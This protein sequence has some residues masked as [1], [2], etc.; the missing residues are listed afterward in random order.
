[1]N[2]TTCTACAVLGPID[3]DLHDMLIAI[4]SGPDS[5]VA[6]FDWVESVQTTNPHEPDPAL[7]PGQLAVSKLGQFWA[8]HD[9]IVNIVAV[10]QLAGIVAD[11]VTARALQP[12]ASACDGQCQCREV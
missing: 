2:P 9:S 7:A 12:C 6:L 10:N 11:Y 3:A 4:E 5:V 1:M 8:L